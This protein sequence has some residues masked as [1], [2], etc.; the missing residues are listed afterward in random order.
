MSLSET[1]SSY[2]NVNL[3]EK[4]FIL[5]LTFLH[6]ILTLDSKLTAALSFMMYLTDAQ[7]ITL[8]TAMSISPFLLTE[9]E[10]LFLLTEESPS[11][12]KAARNQ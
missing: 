1:S 8:I 3:K 4:P 6:L 9:Q 12:P 7:F 10:F 5:P 2:S 11:T